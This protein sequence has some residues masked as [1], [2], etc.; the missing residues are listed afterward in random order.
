[1][2]N[3]LKKDDTLIV[4]GVDN[5]FFPNDGTLSIPLN[6]VIVVI[7]SSDMAVFKSASNGD[8]IFSALIGNIRIEGQP[9]TKDDIISKFDAVSNAASGGGGGDVDA[10]TKSESD[11]RYGTLEEQKSLRNDVEQALGEIAE[12][13]ADKGDKPVVWKID[14]QFDGGTVSYRDGVYLKLVNLIDKQPEGF[15]NIKV[16]DILEDSKGSRAIV[17][18]KDRYLTDYTH[19]RADFMFGS[20]YDNKVTKI[21]IGFK[22]SENRLYQFLVTTNWIGLDDFSDRIADNTYKLT[23]RAYNAKQDLLVS[24]TNIKTINGESI[25]GEG[26]I[27]LSGGGGSSVNTFV[28][29]NSS[30]TTAQR[31]TSGYPDGLAGIKLGDILQD[32]DGIKAVVTSVARE[33]ANFV[34]VYTANVINVKTSYDSTRYN[35]EWNVYVQTR[36]VS[37]DNVVIEKVPE[38][39]AGGGSSGPT[40]HSCSL[41]PITYKLTSEG[42]NNNYLSINAGN[43]GN[44]VWQPGLKVGDYISCEDGSVWFVTNKNGKKFSGIHVNEPLLTGA[45]TNPTL[46][47][48]LDLSKETGVVGYFFT[49]A[50]IKAAGESR[51]S[52]FFKLTQGAYDAKQD[53]LVS[54]TNVKTINGQSILGSGDIQ[55]SGGGG[56]YD[57]TELRQEI[58][59]LN[60]QVGNMQT[61]VTLANETALNA[62]MTAEQANQTAMDVQNGLNSASDRIQQLEENQE[63]DLAKLTEIQGKLNGVDSVQQKLSGNYLATFVQNGGS[64]TFTQRG[65]DGLSSSEK[66]INLK[67]VN[68]QSLFGMGDIS[69]SG[70]KEWT[71][72]QSQYDAL[73][74]YDDNTTYY[75]IG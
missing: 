40:Q 14:G 4:E 6:S 30:F 41:S 33:M 60:T 25:L 13:E 29:T 24:G 52:D 32:K 69:I 27:E 16:G 23:Q 10:Y 34:P 43:L 73:G 49:D 21:D 66:V 53:K 38:P 3:I 67:T 65:F 36:G 28:F 56:S 8:V 44:S 35:G 45:N 7:D 50:F 57:D 26:D 17:T 55:I 64:I 11:A 74:T 39:E 59:E 20:G 58:D 18:V 37:V 68:G 22:V 19:F 61:D 70:T 9:V 5:N 15:E 31:L 62:Q 2:L 1:M 42:T 46:Y 12:L 48:S 51:P 71:G 75:I 63:Q 72:T 54:G 47:F